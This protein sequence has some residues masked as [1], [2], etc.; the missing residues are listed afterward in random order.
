M[1]LIMDLNGLNP[2]QGYQLKFYVIPWLHKKKLVFI[3]GCV[4]S[5]TLDKI[6]QKTFDVQSNCFGVPW[7][8]SW[9][10]MELR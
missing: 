4:S 10:E 7:V 2:L 5:N 8:I 9:V 1:N 3:G 6:W